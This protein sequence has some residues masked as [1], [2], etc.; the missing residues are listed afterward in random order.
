MKLRKLHIEDYKMFKNFDISFVDENDE[1][2]PIV[3]LAGVNGSGKS[4]LLS[5]IF[6]E[7]Y[8]VLKE[9]ELKEKSKILDG[10]IYGYPS[11]ITVDLQPFKEKKT[12]LIN[13]YFIYLLSGIDNIKQV[14][15]EFVK[16]FYFF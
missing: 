10:D 13:D 1:A 16:T 8:K 9:K 12:I 6:N 14:A 7:Y 2:L 5:W 11:N 15:D 3:I 4:S